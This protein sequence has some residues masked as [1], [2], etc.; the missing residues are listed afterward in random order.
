MSREPTKHAE[1]GVKK[2]LQGALQAVLIPLGGLDLGA[3][4]MLCYAALF[5]VLFR[6]NGTVGAFNRYFAKYF[7]DHAWRGALPYLYWFACVQIGLGLLPVLAARWGLGSRRS[8][9]LRELGLGLGDW[10][11]G[12]RVS[13]FLFVFMLPFVAVVSM[14]PSFMRQ[15]PLSGVVAQ[16]A[17]TFIKDE[18]GAI[19]LFL[20]YELAYMLY[21]FS[22][23][24]FFR[25]FLSLGLARFIGPIAI[26]VQMLPFALLHVGKPQPE[27]LGSIVA[28]LALGWL[29]LRTRSM[30]WGF[31]LHAAVALSMDLFAL[32]ARAGYWG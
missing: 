6:A 10:R 4:L 26:A 14:Q 27:A 19:G 30:W 25:G 17:L 13:L 31:L 9:S 24:F 29:A 2:A 21:F 5:L 28:G 1:L 16:Q 3:L 7:V 32:A 8:L 18:R 22:W 23:E 15:Y 11:F 20:V 12:L